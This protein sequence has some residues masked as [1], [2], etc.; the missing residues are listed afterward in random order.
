MLREK[1]NSV[2]KILKASSVIS[3]SIIGAG[4]FALPWVS[5]KSGLLVYLFYLLV[6]T[7]LVNVIHLIYGSIVFATPISHR[8]L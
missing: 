4:I 8:F 5:A 1:I 3:G 2:L 7:F 6:L